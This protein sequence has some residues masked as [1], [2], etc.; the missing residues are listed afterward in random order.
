MDGSGLVVQTRL[1]VNLSALT[2]EQVVSKR[3]KMIMD[4]GDG[5]MMEIREELKGKPEYAENAVL[6]IRKGL[7]AGPYSFSPKWYN[8]DENFARAVGM[9]LGLKKTVVMD[10]IKLPVQ[11]DDRQPILNGTFKGFKP[12]R[13]NHQRVLL[14]AAWLKL[15]SKVATL[16]LRAMGL[17]ETEVEFLCYIF[18]QSQYIITADMRE[19][20]EMGVDAAQKLVDVLMSE[21]NTMGSLC[22]VTKTKIAL[23]IPR[24]CGSCGVLCLC[25]APKPQ[26]PASSPKCPPPNPNP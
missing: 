11:V 25:D 10:G 23:S 15:N 4:M 5:M 14:I 21:S 22:G 7:E 18:S 13:N 1:S 2:L 24:R 3:R 19:N 16:D 8:D 17:D 20:G 6:L 9:S 12:N 26:A